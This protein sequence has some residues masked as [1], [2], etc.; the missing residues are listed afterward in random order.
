MKEKIKT[1]FAICVLVLTVP[2]IVTLLF[3][4]DKTSLESGKVQEILGED[5]F[6]DL[7]AEGKDMNVE[8]YLAGV[9]AKEIPLD[10]HI[11]TIKAQ[12]V[13]ARTALTVA[14]ESEDVNLPESMSREEMLELWG[15]E[16]FEENYRVIEEAVTAT[17]GEILIYKEEPIQAAF[18][19]VSAGKTRNAKEALQ[20]EEEPYL[21]SVESELDI[22]CSDYLKVVFLEKNEYIEKIK[23]ACPELETAEDNIM[24]LVTVLKRDS[25]DYVTEIKIGEK[26]VTGEEFRGY[27]NLNSACFYLKEV[28]GKVRIVTKGLGHGLGLSQYGANE[29]AKEGKDYK[30]ILQYYY[31]D[32]EIKKN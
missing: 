26:V 2:Y 4:G 25:S 11:E 24:E 1:F 29:L 31:K 7:Q 9:L 15:R 8:E 13:I 16:G 19:A 17:K 27:L 12:A 3:Q 6:E 10:Y 18:H 14:L 32:I 20:K 23:K 30:E 5:S 21:D 22:P 28:E